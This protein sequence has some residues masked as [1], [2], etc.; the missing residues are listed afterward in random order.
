MS[1]QQEHPPPPPPGDS[2][3]EI[4]MET[5]TTAI[6]SQQQQPPPPPPPP[7]LATPPI[8]SRN[9]ATDSL[10][11]DLRYDE[12]AK[13]NDYFRHPY[14]KHLWK[15]G[16]DKE[17]AAQRATN[18]GDVTLGD[19]LRQCF[20]AP[21]NESI[22]EPLGRVAERACAG[23]PRDFYDRLVPSD[24]KRDLVARALRTKY[25]C[26]FRTCVLPAADVRAALRPLLLFRVDPSSNDPGAVGD[27]EAGETYYSDERVIDLSLL[28][29][30]KDD[31]D[32]EFFVADKLYVRDA[33]RRVFGLFQEDAQL[34][35][36]GDGSK[37]KDKDAAL[38]GSAGVGKAV[39]FFLA[40]LHRAA[41]T[42]VAYY[43]RRPR[44]DRVSFFLMEPVA[45]QGDG[46]DNSD[47]AMSAG[48]INNSVRIWF[49]R[50]VD[51]YAIQENR[52]LCGF[53]RHILDGL[54]LDKK[55]VCTFLDGPRMKE[56]AEDWCGTYDYICTNGPRF[57]KWWHYETRYWV[58]GGW[59]EDDA[60]RALR[61]LGHDE[62]VGR[63]AFGLCGGNIRDVV[64]AAANYSKVKARLD[65]LVAGLDKDTATMVALS[66]STHRPD[67][68]RNRDRLRTVFENPRTE[69]AEQGD[70]GG[71]GGGDRWKTFMHCYEAVDSPFLLRRM[72]RALDFGHFYR[73]YQ[74]VSHEACHRA[75]FNRLVHKWAEGAASDP[76]VQAFDEVCWSSGSRDECVKSLSRPNLYWIPSDPDHP[77]VVDAAL[78]VGATL[79]AFHTGMRGTSVLDEH[80]LRTTFVSAVQFRQVPPLPLE[81]AVVCFVHPQDSHLQC[82]DLST[83]RRCPS[84]PE[85]PPP[86]PLL[87]PPS[88]R[89]RRSRRSDGSVGGGATGESTRLVSSQPAIPIVYGHYQVTTYDEESCSGSLRGLFRNLAESVEYF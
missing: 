19:L 48:G 87:P 85:P 68:P 7:Q 60:R 17:A 9:G 79:Y 22:R 28:D 63:S 86:P 1:V 23:M 20:Q 27:A 24:I 30:L 56:E 73:A 44:D 12:T 52:G 40:A 32:L 75:W 54:T 70:G 29:P 34:G 80:E 81:R 49:T 57:Y 65:R 59:S 46:E 76:Q 61:V 35:D 14:F 45:G 69:E 31:D 26:D 74:R 38:C 51:T 15:W 8:A 58:L 43:R 53:S 18:L 21:W 89:K 66:S 16:R 39:L 3:A 25:A 83:V 50:N 71:G 78:V 41:F 55:E 72:H 47:D 4:A 6:P 88:K 64:A 36:V 11:S 77:H 82:H 42:R 10:P 13:A 33:M 2:N 5:A 37:K 84:T 62:K 67:T